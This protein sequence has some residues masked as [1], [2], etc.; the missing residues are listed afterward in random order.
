MKKF[1]ILAAS[2]IIV[3]PCFGIPQST[4]KK[5]F[6]YELASYWAPD[7]YQDTWYYPEGDYITAFDGDGDWRGANN[8]ESLKAGRFAPYNAYVY[9]QVIETR[10]HYLVIYEVFHPFDYDHPLLKCIESTYHE[11]DT[12]AT[13]VIVQKTKQDKFG[14]FR[15][16]E[17]RPHG[18][19]RYY[20][21][22]P[23]VRPPLFKLIEKPSLRDGHH[24]EIYIQ[25]GG[26]GPYALH[27]REHGLIF[28]HGFVSDTGVVYRYTGEAQTPEGPD[29]RDVG[30]ELLAVDGKRGFWT[31]RC[32]REAFDNRSEYQ[33]PQGRPGI[34]RE[35]LCDDGKL[36]FSLNGDDEG[37]SGRVDA[38]GLPWRHLTPDPAHLVDK[39]WKFP[40][41]FSTEYIYNPFL[42]IDRRDERENRR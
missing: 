20:S 38:G 26:H 19:T 25:G 39:T 13:M 37:D 41:N 35:L 8:L 17:T 31:H 40:E 29:D 30:Y 23:H 15:G 9:Y 10:T 6:Y 2:L 3:L 5:D 11:N 24:P 21:L 1:S 34:P 7:L 18:Y 42:G 28:R 27:A 14:R 4:D 12:E 33:P 32:R 36:P 16:F 22:D